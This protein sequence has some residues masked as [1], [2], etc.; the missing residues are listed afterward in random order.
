MK[1]IAAVVIVVAGL[2]AWPVRVSAQTLTLPALLYR[3]GRPTV[4]LTVASR[5][6]VIAQPRMD[7]QAL[8]AVAVATPWRPSLSTAPI[9][10]LPHRVSWNQTHTA[11]AGAFVASLLIDAGQ[12]RALAR[13][14]WSRFREANPLLGERPSE[15][16]INTY[17]ALAGLSVLGTAAALPPRLRSW[18]L[19]A[20]IAVQTLTISRS[21][22]EGLPITFP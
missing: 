6:Q 4:L 5:A 17:T 19:G 1:R 10:G 3:E 2:N 18:L 15:G 20:A 14:G 13:T 8:R 16:R 21:V 11:L 12:T 9:R 22:R 7:Q